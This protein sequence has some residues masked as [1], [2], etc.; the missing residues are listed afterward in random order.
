MPGLRHEFESG[1]G[2]ARLAK[3]GGKGFSPFT[4]VFKLLAS[5]K[6]GG[7]PLQPPGGVGPDVDHKTS[8]STLSSPEKHGQLVIIALF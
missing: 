1:G 3:I 4:A 7:R 8:E 6:V 2:G 5:Q